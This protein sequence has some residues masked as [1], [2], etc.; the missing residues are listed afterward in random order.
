[1]LLSGR[2]APDT[3]AQAAHLQHGGDPI[4]TSSSVSSMYLTADAASLHD[5]AHTNPGGLLMIDG[6]HSEPN[7]VV[8]GPRQ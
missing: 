3:A 1:M 7:T 6:Q 4:T 8:M 2:S 5:M